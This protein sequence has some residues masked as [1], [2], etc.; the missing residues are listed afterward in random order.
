MKSA[1]LLAGFLLFI[2][3][4]FT[5]CTQDHDYR[6]G[7]DEIITGN[8]GVEFYANPDKT[9]EFSTYSLQFNSNG[10]VQGTNGVNTVEGNWTVVHDVDRTDVLSIS[11]NEQTPLSELNNKWSVTTKSNNALALKLRGGATEFRI[12]KL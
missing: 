4:S 12:R 5:N 3:F 11:I 10:K 2:S 7:T 9:A 6:F 8:W 1:K